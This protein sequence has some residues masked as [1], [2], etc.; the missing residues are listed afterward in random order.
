VHALQVEIN[1]G[2][3]LDEE[4]VS[5]GPKFAEVQMRIARVLADLMAMDVTQ[6]RPD[7]ASFR[8]A[9]E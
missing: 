2:L 5:R 3:Y 7:G 4:R 6:L 9:A 1:R 8:H